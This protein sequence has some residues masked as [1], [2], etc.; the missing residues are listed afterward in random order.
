MNEFDEKL[1]I[2]NENYINLTKKEF[3]KNMQEKKLKKIVEDVILQK[4][5]TNHIEIKKAEGGCP[6]IFDTLSSFSN[7]K[8]GG[9]ILFGIDEKNDFQICG[10]YDAADIIK[11][12]SE[13]CLQMEPPVKALCTTTAIDGKIVVCAEIPEMDDFQKPCFYKGSGRLRGS[14]VRVGD[15]DRQM[16]EYEVYTYEAFKKKIEDEL[17]PVARA[18]EKELVTDAFQKFAIELKNKKPNVASLPVARQ[19]N[20]LGFV[21]DHHPTVAGL[22]MF[23]IYPQGFLPGLCI[24]AVVV[25]GTE[26]SSTGDI[27]ERFIDNKK[28]EGTIRQMREDAVAFVVRNMRYRTIV[29]EQTGEREDRPEYPIIAIREIILNALVHRDYSIHTDNTPITIKMFTDRIEVENPGGL[30]GRNRIETLGEFGADTRNPYL[31]NALE[32]IGQAE[33]RYSGIP[34]IRRSMEDARLQPPKF[35]SVHGV[36]RVTLFNAVVKDVSALLPLQQEILNYCNQPRSR[37][38][39][40]E[41]F[42]DKLTIA[43]L[44]TQ[45]IYPMVEK[46]LLKMSIPGKP[47]SKNQRFTRV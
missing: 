47:K 25:P 2:F 11:K 3:V 21:A 22:L 45:F 44:M 46:G 38:E 20:L 36:F 31:A 1:L 9:V 37:K 29:N 12:I 8:D 18:T 6:K 28:I 19:L 10:V 27:G 4:C 16:T 33:N 15:S 39:L 24:T 40:G 34:T 17:R 26:V 5:E 23:G 35:E 13:Q 32:I 7:Q 41:K 14:F 30:Y 43:Y 42:R